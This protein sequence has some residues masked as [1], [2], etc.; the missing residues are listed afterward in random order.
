MDGPRN[1][2][3]LGNVRVRYMPVISNDTPL[4]WSIGG[5][6]PAPTNWQSVLNLDL[7]DTKYVFT[8]DTGDQDFYNIDPI[9]NAPTIFGVEIGGAYRQDDAT[10]RF[11]AN[12]IRS[13]ATV[14]TGVTLA[15]NQ[16]YTFTYDIFE[17]NP[18]TGLGWSNAEVNA[19]DVGPKVVG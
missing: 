17:L 18:D 10:Q 4:D 9:I 6:I 1:N 3:Y 8:P 11:V 13:G 5:S 15:T 14:A 2:D 7:N 19:I 12:Q 16:T